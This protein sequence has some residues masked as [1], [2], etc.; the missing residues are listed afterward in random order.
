M[1]WI[2]MA[3]LGVVGVACWTDWR[4][5]RIPNWLTGSAIGLGLVVHFLQNGMAGVMQSLI[6][7]LLGLALLL[8]LFLRGGIGGGDV[9][10]LMALGALTGPAFLFGAFLL[11]SVCGAL[12]SLVVIVRKSLA[13]TSWAGAS[14]P[15]ALPIAAGVVLEMARQSGWLW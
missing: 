1:Q 9:K 7:I 5:R 13:R 2:W 8:I 11:G 4:E 15:Y 10:L 14:I 3:T 6:G 12:Y